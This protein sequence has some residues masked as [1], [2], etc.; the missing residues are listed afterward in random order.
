MSQTPIDLPAGVHHET[1]GAAPVLRIETPASTAV[2]HLDGAQVTSWIPT[3]ARDVL[4]LSPATKTGPG[5]AIRGGIPL[6]GPWFGPGRDGSTTP[7]HGW[8]RTHRWELE[9]AERIGDAITLVLALDDADPSGHGISARLFVSVGE[10]LTVELTVTAGDAPLELEA[11]LH[12]YLAVS[13][14]RDVHLEGFAGAHYLDNRDGLT[15]KRQ[16]GPLRLAGW[17]DR[18]Y[19]VDGAVEIRDP[20]TSRTVREEPAGSTRT[21]VW[22]P[23]DEGATGMADIPDDAWPEFVCVET[24]ACKDG[25]VPLEP[26][27]SHAIRVRFEVRDGAVSRG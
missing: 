1:E 6:V 25:F 4:W 17:T 10:H 3:G 27:R 15:R 18:I 22:N 11:A 16:E 23:W 2:L 26:G 14:V 5:E 9:A 7:A 12:T 21:V 19:E 20:G 24:A 13:D 8:L